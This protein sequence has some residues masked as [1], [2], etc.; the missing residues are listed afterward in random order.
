[1]LPVA[2][3]KALRQ[4]LTSHQ[5]RFNYLNAMISDIP[6]EVG[7]VLRSHFIPRF[8]KSA[9]KGIRILPGAGFNGIGKIIAGDGVIIGIDNFFQASAGL[10]I[11][12][13]TMFG[14]GVK[15]WTIN[16][17][18]EALDR[19]IIEQGYDNKPVSIGSH[20]W[21]G[22]NVFVM[23]GVEIPDGCIVSAGAVVGVKKF[24]PYSIIAGNPARAIGT[25][26]G[27]AAP[28]GET[29]ADEAKRGE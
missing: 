21:I 29:E 15:I 3:L 4:D 7:M 23:P 11:G 12:D 9:G 1:M 6:G 24:P 5:Q 2:L 17:R 18:F 8:F 22:S 25:R 19:P 14:P 16:H 10:T 26:L 13:H 20:V 27:K 28:N